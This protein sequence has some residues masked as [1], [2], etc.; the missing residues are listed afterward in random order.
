METFIVN[1]FVFYI[2]II[3]ILIMYLHIKLRKK[4]L[5]ILEL[6]DN[7]RKQDDIIEVQKDIIEKQKKIIELDSYNTENRKIHDIYNRI[8]E[9]IPEVIRTLLKGNQ[10][11]IIE[12]I[13]SCISKVNMENYKFINSACK[14][15]NHVMCE[16]RNCD[17][18]IHKNLK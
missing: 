12:S 3:S 2:I 7:V 11:K 4:E 5:Q 10:G 14:N 17:N 16:P 15:Y 13:V 18:C 1:I 8:N 9:S 6:K